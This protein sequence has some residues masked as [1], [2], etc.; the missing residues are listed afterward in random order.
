MVRIRNISKCLMLVAVFRRYWNSGHVTLNFWGGHLPSPVKHNVCLTWH[1]P[2]TKTSACC[3][4]S[5]TYLLHLTLL[6][7]ETVS[8]SDVMQLVSLVGTMCVY[9]KVQSA[10]V[11]SKW[12][13]FRL[14]IYSTWAVMLIKLVSDTRRRVCIMKWGQN[15][16][17]QYDYVKSRHIWM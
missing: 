16:F 7:T 9:W 3:P 11:N 17:V 5:D 1:F 6:Y 8:L 10:F 15:A 12:V 13:N 4:H 14:L 2:N